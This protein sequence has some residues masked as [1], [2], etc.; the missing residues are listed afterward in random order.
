MKSKFIIALVAIAVEFNW[1]AEA[2]IYDTNNVVVQTFAGSGFAGYVD[3]V[4][5]L[6]MFNGP[7]AVVA[8]SHGSLFVW[9]SGNSK[10]RKIT[11]DSTVLTFV[12]PPD[13]YGDT[14]LAIGDED[15]I[16]KVTYSSAYLC[17]ITSGA[18]V[19]NLFLSSR[20][21][22]AGGI[23]IDPTGN[24]FIAQYNDHQ[25][26]RYATNGGLEVFAGSGNQGYADGN[27]IF[28]AFSYPSR[29]AAD[30]VGNIYVWD[31]GNALIRRIDPSR[32]VTTFAGKFGV[33]SDQDGDGANATFGAIE[34][35]CFDKSGNMILAC[36]SSVRKASMTTNVTTLAGSFTQS[37]YTNGPGILARFSRARG[38]CVS[39]NTIFVA[40][41]DNQRIR[42]LNYNP[43]PEPVVPANLQLGTYAGLRIV[44]MVGRAYQI[45]SSPDMTNWTSRATMLLP[46]SPYL[47]IDQAPISGS[48]FYR[49]SLLP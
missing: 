4:G 13:S 14:Y 12:Q 35:M 17:K 31:S 15:T 41:A 7:G 22:Q 33:R 40:D 45:Q 44:G 49:A 48:K 3:G 10:I 20:L 24:I 47:W 23:C 38:V 34:Q 16:W 30:A 25:I 2:Q 8:D 28:T 42:S 19:T 5:T 46:A 29:L 27:G 6:T 11:Q 21:S 39:G 32:N 43:S 37:G 1:Q 9:D 18:N 36:G 26:W